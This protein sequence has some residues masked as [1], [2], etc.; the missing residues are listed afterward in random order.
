MDTIE[1]ELTIDAPIQRVWDCLTTAEHLGTWFGDA[2]A[3]IDL[4]PG[5]AMS[6]SWAAHGRHLG[7]VDEVVAPTR[8]VM[9]WSRGQDTAPRPGAETTVTFTLSPEGDT[10]TRLNLVESGFESLIDDP[11]ALAQNSGGWT[12]ELDELVAYATA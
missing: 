7:I 10:K 1:R 4:R 2:G 12:A 11:D 6:L 8:F 3:T 5:D 9:R